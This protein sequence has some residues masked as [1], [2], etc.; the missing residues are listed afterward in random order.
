MMRV[1]VKCV[2]QHNFHTKL[3]S[4]NVAMRLERGVG[5]SCDLFHLHQHT[6]K[7]CHLMGG[8]NVIVPL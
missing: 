4:Y 7:L 3:N 5:R 6:T 1:A 2:K 8:G